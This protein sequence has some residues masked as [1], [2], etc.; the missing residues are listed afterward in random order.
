MGH[1]N[2]G[3]YLF[4][5]AS[6]LGTVASPALYDFVVN[7]EG[8]VG[9]GINAPTPGYKLDVNGATRLSPGNGTMQFGSPN[10]EL[11][12]SI[13]PNAGNRADLRFDGSVLKLV[14]DTGV[15]PPST[16]NGLAVTIAGNVGIGTT[17]P[18]AKLHVEKTQPGTAVYGHALG[19]GGIGVY[20]HAPNTGGIGVLGSAGAG[21]IGVYA[22]STAGGTAVHA[23]GNATQA[24][25]KGGF[26]KAMAYIDPF[27]PAAQ[28][29]VRCYNSQQAGNAASAAP[30]GIT[31]TRGSS[32]FYVVDFGFNVENRFVSLTPQATGT[33]PATLVGGFITGVSGNQVS[34]SFVRT[35]GSSRDESEDCRFHIIVY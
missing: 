7:D 11:G 29:V 1:A 8:N 3:F 18:D 34:L 27:L 19:A 6:N 23:D 26:V 17:A 15:A 2:T 21:S 13:T 35:G 10:A 30:C 5:T 24:R 14:A 33:F 12:L 16:A 25:D 28:Y 31:V 32:G 22:G 20:G 4:R 9:I